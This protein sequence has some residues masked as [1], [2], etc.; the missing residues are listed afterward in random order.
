MSRQHDLTNDPVIQALR[1]F[2]PEAPTVDRDQLMYQAGRRAAR[3]PRIWP[4]LAAAL[5]ITQTLTLGLWLGQRGEERPSLSRESVP[6]AETVPP[7]RPPNPH[8]YA[9]LRKT[10]FDPVPDRHTV[11]EPGP[12]Q[13]VQRE[14]LTVRSSLSQLEFD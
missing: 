9:A 14:P 11:K 4:S 13:V 6:L 2:T 12:H 7:G 5:L 1:G 3:S 8:S 10:I